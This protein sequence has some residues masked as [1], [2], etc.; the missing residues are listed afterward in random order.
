MVETRTKKEGGFN[1]HN[2]HAKYLENLLNATEFVMGD[3]YR[4]ETIPQAVHFCYS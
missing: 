3:M 1:Q 2:V 4:D